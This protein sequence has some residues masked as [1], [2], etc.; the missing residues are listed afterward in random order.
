M[1]TPKKKKSE[2]GNEP[3]HFWFSII[4]KTHYTDEFNKFKIFVA[5]T[6]IVWENVIPFHPK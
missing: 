1:N 3:N 6:L 4:E 2:I 5:A